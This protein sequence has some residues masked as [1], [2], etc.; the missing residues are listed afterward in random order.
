MSDKTNVRLTDEERTESIRM[1]VYKSAST[2]DLIDW[3]LK[4]HPEWKRAERDQIQKALRTCN[5]YHHQCSQKWKTL[6]SDTFGHFRTQ[7]ADI[8]ETRRHKASDAFSDVLERLSEVRDVPV[9]TTTDIVNLTRA[10]VQILKDILPPPAPTDPKHENN[11][12]SRHAS[13][14]PIERARQHAGT[15]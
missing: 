3:L 4:R 11:T 9:E 2:S 14:D 15:Y 10:A 5:P 1:R 8:V 6:H 12:E 7:Q 13:F